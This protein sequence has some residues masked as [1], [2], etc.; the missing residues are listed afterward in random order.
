MA[1]LCRPCFHTWPITPTGLIAT[2][3]RFSKPPIGPSSRSG[4][5]AFHTRGA[6]VD[7]PGGAIPKLAVVVQAKQVRVRRKRL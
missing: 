6:A 7:R 1:R 3:S 2:C 5:R 4:H